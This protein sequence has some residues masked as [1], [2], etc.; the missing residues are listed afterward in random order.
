MFR[1][2]LRSLLIVLALGPP[3][4]G[5]LY[6]LV[7]LENWNPTVVNRRMMERNEERQSAP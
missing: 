1:Y 6:W 5:F 4:M 3:V 7:V 2:R